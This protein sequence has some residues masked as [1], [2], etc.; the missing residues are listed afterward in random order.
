M[1]DDLEK[2]EVLGKLSAIWRRQLVSHAQEANGV[3][4]FAV[5]KDEALMGWMGLIMKPWIGEFNNNKCLLMPFGMWIH[6]KAHAAETV[7]PFRIVLKGK[8]LVAKAWIGITGLKYA[9]RNT[10]YGACLHIPL[11]EF[12][13]VDKE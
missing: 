8:G 3:E 1:A 5:Y 6:L 9:V 13:S 4:L 7:T 12:K 10:K 2:A 11:T